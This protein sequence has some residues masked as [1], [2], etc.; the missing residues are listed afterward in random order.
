[1]TDRLATAYMQALLSNEN[2]SLAETQVKSLVSQKDRA[3]QRF[4]RGEGTRIDVAQAV[5]SLD[6]A[7][8]QLIEAQ[9]SLQVAVRTLQR[10]TGVTTT[11]LRQPSTD[12]EPPPIEPQ[13]MQDWLELAR[14]QNPTIQARE[15]AVVAARMGVD[16]NMS[17]HLPRLDLVA[18]VGRS[19]NESLANLNQSS[20]LKSIGVQLS[21]PIYSGGGVDASVKQALSDQARVEQEARS[22]REAIEI[23]VQR[24][25]QAVVNGSNKLAAYQRVV[26][27]NTVLLEGVTRGADAGMSTFV[28]VLDAQSKLYQAKRD[29]AQTRAEYLL[30]R[31]RLMTQ[32]GVPMADVIQEIDRHLSQP[33]PLKMRSTS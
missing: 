30:A 5:S 14:R 11:E 8:V 31:L 10:L 15:Q 21:V 22:D 24:Q 20:A 2:V 7:R 6:V 1:M 32:A 25:Y 13:G 29:L 16:R 23:E 9:D 27:S 26:T 19:R 18:S 3:E 12:F 17:G 28:D 4:R 33:S